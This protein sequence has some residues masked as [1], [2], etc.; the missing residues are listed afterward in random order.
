MEKATIVALSITRSKERA[1]GVVQ[2]A[3]VK[4]MTT[5]RW[6]G[7]K[8]LAVHFVGI[9]MSLINIEHRSNRQKREKDTAKRYQD[10]VVG[11]TGASPEDKTLKHGEDEVRDTSAMGE[12]DELERRV[13]RLPLAVRILKDQRENGPQKAGVLAKKLEV[14]V[15]DVYKANVMLR[16]H[17][18]NI[19]AGVPFGRG[20]GED[21]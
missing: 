11:K 13:A 14:P 6:D 19:R 4:L 16:H 7:S 9:V 17:L 8:P 15:G 2:D 1:Q 3:C 12:L 20:S 18:D 21:E 10:E 5:R